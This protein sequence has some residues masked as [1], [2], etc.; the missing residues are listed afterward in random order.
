MRCIS[1][2]VVGICSICMEAMGMEVFMSGKTAR[3][4][5]KEREGRS[6][7]H[8]DIHPDQGRWR[9][10]RSRPCHRHRTWSG[11]GDR[12]D[13]GQ[14]SGTGNN[15]DSRASRSREL[16]RGPGSTTR[17]SRRACG[18]AG[19]GHRTCCLE[20]ACDHARDASHINNQQPN[21]RKP[22]CGGF[23]TDVGFGFG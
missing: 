14:I 1:T 7:S 8:N 16:L 17:D 13:D 21:N 4:L 9:G 18:D 20:C 2:K 3:R 10:S 12:D 15:R 19:G 23:R 11:T 5:R 22:G 6:M